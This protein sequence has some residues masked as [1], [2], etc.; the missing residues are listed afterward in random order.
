MVFA[1]NVETNICEERTMESGSNW[2][3]V[4]ST[5]ENGGL[6]I[7]DLLYAHCFACEMVVEDGI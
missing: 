5:A 4:C 3:V 6:S 2:H 1:L 7:L